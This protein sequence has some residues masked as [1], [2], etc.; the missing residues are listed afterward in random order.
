[1]KKYVS[2]LLAITTVATLTS[3]GSNNKQ[4]DNETQKQTEIEAQADVPE[5][6]TIQSAPEFTYTAI[7]YEG[8]KKYFDG[9]A[10]CISITDENHKELAVAID[11]FFAEKMKDYNKAC[12]GYAKEAEKANEKVSKDK[13]KNEGAENEFV[14]DYA[15]HYEYNIYVT[16]TRCDSKVFSFKLEEYAFEGGA[17]GQS[18]ESG[19][20]FDANTGEKINFMG[21]YVDD[22]KKQV[23]DNIE[24]SPDF[25]KKKL[26][27]DYK[28]TI[29]DYFKNDLAD[30]KC[31]LD[32]RGATLSIGAGE[33][34]PHSEGNIYFT[35]PY[36]QMDKLDEKFRREGGFFDANISSMGLADMIDVYGEGEKVAVYLEEE[37]CGEE[38]LGSVFTLHLGDK[39][40]TL[41]GGDEGLLFCNPVFVHST[42]GDFIFIE[43]THQLDSYKV[44]MFDVA[45]DCKKIGKAEGRIQDIEDGQITLV[46]TVDALGT[47]P[48]EKI[49]SYTKDGLSTDEKVDR[50]MNNPNDMDSKGITTKAKIGYYKKKDGE[51]VEAT[52]ARG[53]VIYPVATDGKELEFITEDGETGYFTYETKE[54][55]IYIDGVSENDLFESLPYA[56]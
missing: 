20:A 55:V 47:W 22:F 32:Y 9:A 5:E 8:D 12:D 29:E 48:S 54:Y 42:A 50:L 49:Y 3:C 16:V 46:K 17:H 41:G 33:I 14:Y 34:A 27:D 10:Q 15:P 4:D 56:G 18:V 31:W 6:V 39:T 38:H 21:D 11:D 25:A 43:Q 37:E 26:F 1:M 30:D 40:I 52:L 53:T 19:Y 7:K 51:K 36:E 45:K 28:D 2:I 44:E 35:L 23:F 13:E 24:A